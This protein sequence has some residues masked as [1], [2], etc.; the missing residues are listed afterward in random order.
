MKDERLISLLSS[1]EK[2]NNFDESWAAYREALAELG[3]SNGNF[4]STLTRNPTKDDAFYLHDYSQEFF[5]L[6]NEFNGKDHDISLHHAIALGK[7]LD[8][9]S[10]PITQRIELN[11]EQRLI[12]DIS[13]EYGL[14]NG[15]SIPFYNAN[16]ELYGGVGLCA[17]GVSYQE[18][19]KDIRH[20]RTFIDQ[21]TSLFQAYTDRHFSYNEMLSHNT[22]VI[23]ELTDDELETIKWL[24]EGK[25]TSFI[26][27]SI[28]HKSISSI[29]KS[30]SSAKQ[31][32][33]VSSK[34]QLIY[35]A[36]QL[37]LIN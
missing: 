6:Y 19:D 35:R 27:D 34:D 31:K 18:F 20:E 1:L 25:T 3:L 12:E 13:Y 10:N 9:S 7:T 8:W 32:L 17:Q 33:K 4:L 37:G 5:D 15:Y 36:I 30:I 21:A 11:K 22:S 28:I 29:D 23:G 2:A 26:A 24:S 14:N 16:G